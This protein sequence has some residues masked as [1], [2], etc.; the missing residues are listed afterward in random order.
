MS[1][2]TEGPWKIINQGKSNDYIVGKNNK[3]ITPI[4][5]GIA[6]YEANI[7]LICAA[8][9]LLYSIKNL[10][11]AEDNGGP[12]WIEVKKAI[13]KAEGDNK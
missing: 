13:T 12:L 10:M 9:D 6:N 11:E 4:Y 2:H 3:A 8:P 7:R 5:R 1:K